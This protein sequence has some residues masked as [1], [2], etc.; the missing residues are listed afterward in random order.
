M[1]YY[2]ILL[3]ALWS[4]MTLWFL[5]SL[6]KKRNDVADIAWGL[7]FILLAWISFF[8]SDSFHARQLLINIL[9][10]IWGARLAI[11]IYFRNK[12]KKEDYRYK[13]WREKWGRWFYLRSYLQVYLLQGTLLYL[14]VFPVLLIHNN[15]G[16]SLGFLDVFG[17]LLW[18]IGF[19]FET[20]G[21]LQLSGFIKNPANKGKLMDKGLWKYTRHPNYFGEVLQWWA[22]WVI[23]LS[24]EYGAYGVIGPLTIT[25][26]I[27]KISGIPMLEKSL[28]KHPEFEEYKK[29]TSIFF[30]LPPRKE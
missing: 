10:T 6:L 11:H 13:E 20:V 28:S 21:D 2:L 30:P 26:L 9:I 27:L 12:G 3:V 23:A 14:I 17:V 24:V 29:K 1:N 25:I 8:L 19:F 15:P 5:V 16:T 7:G 18:L 22:V 4:Y